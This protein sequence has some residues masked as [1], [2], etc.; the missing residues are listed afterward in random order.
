MS[1][2]CGL[3]KR[4]LWLHSK[5][6]VKFRIRVDSVIFLGVRTGNLGSCEMHILNNRLLIKRGRRV[7]GQT[8]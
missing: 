2:G 6:Q 4:M 1:V 8:V 5:R 3:F 7:D